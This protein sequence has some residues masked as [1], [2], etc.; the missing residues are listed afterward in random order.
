MT[1][2]TTKITVGT[3][4]AALA[5]LTPGIA[6]ATEPSATVQQATPDLDG[7]GYPDLATLTMA[8]DGQQRLDFTVRGETTSVQLTGDPA[9]GVQPMR[10]TDMNGDGRQEVVVVESVGANT[11]FSTVW[12]HAGSGPRALSTSDGKPLQLAEG[13]GM[14]ARLGYECA[15]NAAGGRDLITLQVSRDDGDA[16]TYTGSRVRYEITDD[17]VHQVNDYTISSVG[18]DDPV[19]RTAPASCS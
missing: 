10:V 18:Q 8:G 4:A 9:Q 11:T 7:D 6:S 2:T 1:S 19:L 16:V 12:D 17:V 3:L 14:A 15:S 13:G 5:L